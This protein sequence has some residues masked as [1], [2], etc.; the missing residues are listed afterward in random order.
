[1]AI[2]P[3][4]LNSLTRGG[5]NMLGSQIELNAEESMKFPGEE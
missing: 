3:Q 1:M 5:T 2:A 4:D